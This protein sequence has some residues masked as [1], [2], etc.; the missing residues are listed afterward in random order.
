MFN[1]FHARW[2]LQQWKIQIVSPHSVA[3]R[4]SFVLIYGAISSS[5]RPNLSDL[6]GSRS[7]SFSDDG[8]WILRRLQWSLLKQLFVL[9]YILS[10][11]D[12]DL[13][14]NPLEAKNISP[15]STTLNAPAMPDLPLPANL[16]S[17]YKPRQKHFSAHV[18]P[19]LGIAPAEPPNYGPLVTFAHPPSSSRLSKLLMKKSGSVPPSAGPAPLH[20]EELAPIS[21]ATIPAGLAQPPLSPYASSKTHLPC[22]TIE[23]H[24]Q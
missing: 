4:L 2:I 9:I 12:A 3:W 15:T 24:S 7:I 22:G 10:V 6:N 18:A 16:P 19:K 14:G 13:P 11:T 21:G 23:T 5:I 1:E 8:V 20:S 17:F